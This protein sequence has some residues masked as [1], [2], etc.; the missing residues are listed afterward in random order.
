MNPDEKY[1][2]YVPDLTTSYRLYINSELISENGI[3]GR[4]YKSE[5]VYL[6]PKLKHFRPK[7]STAE[8]VMQIFKLSLLS[9]RF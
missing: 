5:H 4:D 3:Q 2:L 8:L 6:K 7:A 9:G 1:I